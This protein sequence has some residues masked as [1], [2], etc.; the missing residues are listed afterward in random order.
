[1]YISS[2]NL[3]VVTLFLENAF[4]CNE[5]NKKQHDSKV[6]LYIIIIIII[7]I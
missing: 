6:N 4:T 5:L 7:I 2:K 3:F 1:L